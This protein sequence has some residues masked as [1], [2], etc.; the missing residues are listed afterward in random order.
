MCTIH[1]KSKTTL[2]PEQFI[3]GLTDF[4]EDRSELFRR[5]AQDYLVVHRLGPTEADVTEGTAHVWEHLHYDWSDPHH[6]VVKTVYSNIWGGPSGYTYRLTPSGDGR[7]TI[8]LALVREGKNSE[9]RLLAAMLRTLG[10]VGLGRD[11]AYSIRA[12]EAKA[13]RAPS[14]A[15]RS[16]PAPTSRWRS[17]IRDQARAFK[18]CVQ[19]L[20]S[21]RQGPR[22][23]GPSRRQP[24]LRSR[25]TSPIP[26]GERDALNS[27][28]RPPRHT[29]GVT[30]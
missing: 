14:P 21:A 16:G 18:A 26:R 6:I 10:R 27:P 12:I 3:A 25:T 19:K 5:S 23:S 29:P 17:R 7:T 30:T 28:E 1:L 13:I 15:N 11:L 22:T 2:T 24:L 4:G 20:H 9:G 8:R